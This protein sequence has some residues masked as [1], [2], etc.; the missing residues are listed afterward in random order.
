MLFSYCEITRDI[1]NDFRC[2]K[3]NKFDR[4]NRF[5]CEYTNKPFTNLKPFS[6]ISPCPR[7][8]C[9]NFNNNVNQCFPNHYFPNNC[10]HQNEQYFCPPF[11]Q[12]N[13]GFQHNFVG[14]F[15]CYRPHFNNCLSCR[16]I[17]FF[18]TG[19]IIRK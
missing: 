8:S 18:L 16:D 17:A 15:D 2:N 14:Q 11:W 1:M 10:F 6:C 9:P 4:C 19:Y 12:N 13:N 5:D 3:C 7:F